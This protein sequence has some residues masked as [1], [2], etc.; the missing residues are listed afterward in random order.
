MRSVTRR[1]LSALAT[2]TLA[3]SLLGTQPLASQAGPSV[4]MNVTLSVY[5]CCGSLQGFN[6]NDPNNVFSIYNIFHDRLVKAFPNLKWQEHVDLRTPGQPGDQADPGRQ[7]RQPTRHGVHPGRL[8]GL[9]GAAEAGPAARQVFHP[10]Q[11]L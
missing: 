8:H 1:V 9:L 2:L 5:T 6:S 3:S 10:V 4:D 7:L 11:R